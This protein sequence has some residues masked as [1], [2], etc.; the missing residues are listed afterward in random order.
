M[1]KRRGAEVVAMLHITRP[2]RRY[3][4]PVETETVSPGM[5]ATVETKVV[6]ATIPTAFTLPAPGIALIRFDKASTTLCRP[7]VETPPTERAETAEIPA[8]TLVAAALAAAA[9]PSAL[10]AAALAVAAWASTE[11]IWAEI[12]TTLADKVS[13]L[14]ASA[15]SSLDVTLAAPATTAE[16]RLDNAFTTLWSP[17]VETPPTD[18]AETAEIPART[19]VAAAEAAAA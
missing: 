5:P 15:E 4:F 13:T 19:L 10:V 17:C 11:T 2:S 1:P 14:A 6:V 7:C 12:D 9:C 18:R 8:K 16:M 3:N